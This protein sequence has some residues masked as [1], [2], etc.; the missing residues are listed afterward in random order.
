MPL[1]S[2]CSWLR[3]ERYDFDMVGWKSVFEGVGTCCG[4]RATVLNSLG[5]NF[6]V[7]IENL[8]VFKMCTFS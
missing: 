2:K 7:K 3:Y 4:A 8:K 6:T 5:E 1:K